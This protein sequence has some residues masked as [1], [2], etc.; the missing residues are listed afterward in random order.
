MPRKSRSS[1]KDIQ[2]IMGYKDMGGIIGFAVL[3]A[4]LGGVAMGIYQSGKSVNSSLEYPRSSMMGLSSGEGPDVIMNL[5]IASG[6]L[7]L[8][9]FFFWAGR[10]ISLAVEKRGPDASY[11]FIY[12]FFTFVILLPITYLIVD[13]ITMEAYPFCNNHPEHCVI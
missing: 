3:S 6:V 9:A 2:T 12:G 7:F 8:V 5:D 13:W 11:Y 1:K 10:S 4:I